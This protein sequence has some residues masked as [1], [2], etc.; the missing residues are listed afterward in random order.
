VRLTMRAA[1]TLLDDVVTALRTEHVSPGVGLVLVYFAS[2][3]LLGLAR[4]VWEVV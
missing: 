4:R 3:A 2:R 1:R